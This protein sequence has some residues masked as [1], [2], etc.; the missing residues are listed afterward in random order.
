MLSSSCCGDICQTQDCVRAAINLGLT[1][2]FMVRHYN[3]DRR[4]PYHQTQTQWVVNIHAELSINLTV[5]HVENVDHCAKFV[6]LS[7]GEVDE[8]KRKMPKPDKER[9]RQAGCW[10][11]M[12]F[13][14]SCKL[15]KLWA[16]LTFPHC[17]RVYG[18]RIQG[19][20]RR[21]RRQKRPAAASACS[22]SPSALSIFVL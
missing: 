19:K 1:S 3:T 14:P 22:S 12:T 16:R 7:D 20:R 11:S 2:L 18:D 21:K 8:Q 4:I 5:L 6:K 15:C 9:R 13:A 10:M 17:D